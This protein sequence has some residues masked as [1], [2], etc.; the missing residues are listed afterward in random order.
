VDLVIRPHEGIGPLSFGMDSTAVRTV[1]GG[2]VRSFRKTPDAKTPTDAFDEHGI[3]V[4]Y[5]EAGRCEA[6]EVSSP[7]NPI[8]QGQPLVGRPFSEVRQLL[9]Q[10]DPDIQIDD[11][12]LTAPSLGVGLFAPFAS[13]SP[14]EPTEGVIVFKKGYYD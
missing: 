13:D 1:L 12:G 6:V 2:A 11:T 14:E 9:E 4:Y 3:H 7:A 5:D 10:I 8:L